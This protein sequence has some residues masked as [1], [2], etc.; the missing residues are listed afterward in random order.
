MDASIFQMN[1]SLVIGG[2]GGIGSAIVRML[3]ENHIPTVV[4]DNN[5]IALDKLHNAIPEIKVVICDL[6][7]PKELRKAIAK[8]IGGTIL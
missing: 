2:A 7:K 1:N 5:K 4:I 3:N 8:Q 6:S